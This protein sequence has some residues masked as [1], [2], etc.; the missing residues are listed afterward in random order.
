MKKLLSATA[1]I[2]VMAM[3]A[4]AKDFDRSEFVIKASTANMDYKLYS[5]S[6][7]GLSGVGVGFYLFPH[8]IGNVHANLYGEVGYRRISQTMEFD[9]EYQVHQNFANAGWYGS[10]GVEY[11]A[12][13]GPAPSTLTF[14][15]YVGAEYNFT[16]RVS[17]FVEVGHNWDMKNS[18]NKLGGYAEIGATF[19]VANDVYLRPSVVRSFKTGANSTQARFEVSF[20]F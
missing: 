16:D 12:G 3:P 17:G 14:A 2:L 1:I 4:I 19:N 15:P 7:D 6:K 9:L 20:A 11:S 5:N 13:V 18:W 8:T 10:I